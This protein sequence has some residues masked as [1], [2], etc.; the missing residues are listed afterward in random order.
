MELLGQTMADYK[1]ICGGKFSLK[2]VLMI[3]DQMV[4]HLLTQLSILE[5]T[6]SETIIHRDLKLENILMGYE[7]TFFQVHLIDFGLSKRYI[8][9]ATSKHIPLKSGKTLLGS[10]EYA[11]INNHNGK[12]LSRRDDL[13]SLAYILIG[14][15]LGDLPWSAYATEEKAH[16]HDQKICAMKSRLLETETARKIP[17]EL[18]TFLEAT[19]RLEFDE[20]PKYT[21]YRRLFK[22]LMIRE[23]YSFDYIYDWILIPVANQVAK[24]M[25]AIDNLL[26]IDDTL[27]KEEEAEIA[28]LLEKYESDPTIIDF[29][30]EEIRKQNKKFDIISPAGSP[31]TSGIEEKKGDK[32]NPKDAGG[33]KNPTKPG[34]KDRDCNLI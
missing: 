2:T 30:L 29:R 23:G 31:R 26:Q 3:A 14:L 4:A 28:R 13:E 21:E 18:R 34:K 20:E 22:E 33:K 11:S 7:N 9:P 6:H 8:D 27:T 15:F 24:R 17:A 12:E 32:P 25:N 10:L 5:F 19:R 1:K 16:E